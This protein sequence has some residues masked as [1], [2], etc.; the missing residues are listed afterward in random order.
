MDLRKKA[1]FRLAA[2]EAEMAALAKEAERLRGFLAVAEDLESNIEAEPRPVGRSDPASED[3]R[4]HSPPGAVESEAVEII[5][6]AGRP[7]ARAEMVAELQRRG[8][9]LGGKEPR[10]NLSTILWRSKA[11]KNIN[12]VG[13]WLPSLGEWGGAGSQ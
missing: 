13:Y 7:V 12:G 8:I 11:I 9:V 3:K 6:A 1:E 10:R 2:V 5:K 4:E